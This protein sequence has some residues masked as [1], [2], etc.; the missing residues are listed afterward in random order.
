[1][2][3][4]ISLICI[5]IMLTTSF[6]INSYAAGEITIIS[7]S[8]EAYTDLAEF[9]VSCA[10]AE[11]IIFELDGEKIGE[12]AGE[13]IFTL[14]NALTVGNHSLRA[15]AV[16]SDKS[17]SQDYIEFNVKKK[18]TKGS[19][20]DFNTYTGGDTAA[21]I[22]HVGQS[23]KSS[24]TK[25]PGKSGAEGDNA[26]YM[27]M[28]TTAAVASGN[29]Y[30]DVTLLEDFGLGTASFKYD[31]KIDDPSTAR[32]SWSYVPLWHKGNQIFYD[33]KIANTETDTPSGWT[34]VNMT[35]NY[36]TR[37]VSLIVGDTPVISD[38]S[39]GE[40][41][42]TSSNRRIRISLYQNGKRKESTRTGFT[43]DNMDFK[44]EIIY[45]LEK[46]QY[47]SGESESWIDY[48]SELPV[49]TSAIKLTLSENLTSEDV[50]DSTVK[51][52]QNGSEVSLDSVEYDSETCSIIVKP[53]NPLMSGA[54]LVLR[55]DDT[56]RFA[57]KT[58]TATGAVLEARMN[59]TKS[60]FTPDA[61][62]LKNNGKNLLSASQLKAGDVISADVT[63]K[64]DSDS[65]KI[66]SAF[67]AVR[68]NGKLRSLGAAQTSNLSGGSSE[69]VNLT[70][71][72]IAALDNEGD[73]SVKLIIC[74]ELTDT[75]PYISFIE[76]K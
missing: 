30:I 66:I 56:V 19:I 40:G 26:L 54:Q 7:P 44:Q 21:G 28:E 52:L 48:S 13:C 68:Q 29:P 74:S 1:M 37:K 71:P 4:F 69:T 5:V 63:L 12:T 23:G 14:P 75:V 16:F 45:G 3:R 11:K 33:G 62:V 58:L 50:S 17:A 46:I 51:L 64:N 10:D 22:K 31:I 24:A 72:A 53:S 34:S 41:K 70:L 61:V 18:F 36:K 9:E 8:T 20:Q 32:I 67:I 38:A 39:W 47:S 76:L 6:A 49:D 73:V 65:E 43:I 15:T 27:K 35:V 60:S 25:V 42:E 55:V 2:K 59:T 57:D